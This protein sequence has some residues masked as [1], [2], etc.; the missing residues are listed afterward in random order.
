MTAFG[1]VV[2]DECGEELLAPAPLE[3]GDG[4]LGADRI[5]AVDGEKPTVQGFWGGLTL[6][7]YLPA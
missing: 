3:L 2:S 1:E 7:G 4:T 6:T 5:G